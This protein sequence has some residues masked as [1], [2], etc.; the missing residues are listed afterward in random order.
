MLR[1]L[2]GNVGAGVTVG[3][4]G[5]VAVGRGVWVGTVVSVADIVGRIGVD[6]TV[7]ET[8]MR[9]NVGVNV[10]ADGVTKADSVSDKLLWQVTNVRKLK[11]IT[12]MANF[13][14]VIV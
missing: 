10:V 9:V 5:W 4:W 11:L 13:F 3:I 6:V 7:A 8:T 14:N 1:K 2:V 12:N